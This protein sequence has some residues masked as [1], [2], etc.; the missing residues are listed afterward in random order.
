MKKLQREKFSLHNTKY[1]VQRNLLSDGQYLRV[2]LIYVLLDNIDLPRH[3]IILFRLQ[4]P[5]K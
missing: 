2:C 3:A 5:G 1:N 4:F